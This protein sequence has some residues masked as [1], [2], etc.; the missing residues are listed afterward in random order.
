MMI[1]LIHGECIEE[2]KKLDAKSVNLVLM[3]PPYNI[4]KD[5]TWDNMKDDAY[6]E[7]MGKVF[8]EVSRV[9][10]DNGSMYFFHNDMPLIARL[11][12]NLRTNS[13][14]VFNSFI[15]LDKG[16]FRALA[17]KNPTEKNNLRLWFNVCE[18][19]LCYVKADADG[20]TGLER[21]KLDVNNFQTLRKYAYD[22]LCYIG[23]GHSYQ[24]NTSK[25]NW[26]TGKRNISVT[27]A[28]RSIFS[29]VGGKA[30]HFMRYGSTQWDLC[31]EQTYNEL[32]DTFGIDKWDGFR[33]YESLRQEYESLRQE[34]ESLRP[35]HHLDANHNN[36]WKFKRD[37]GP[38]Y[39]SCQK[40]IDILERIIRCSTDEDMTVLDCFMGS[41]STGVACVNTNRNFIGIEM[42][43]KYYGIATK[44]IDDATK[45]HNK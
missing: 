27:V 17:W 43:E 34:Y 11:M 7:F 18:Y 24:Q 30:D 40:P 31:T 14:M 33:S 44:R 13:D 20:R 29:N 19:C 16:D 38:N 32:I 23:G 5:K 4:N 8:D 21:V 36:V 9:L 1:N 12:E 22:M 37:K 41:G 15:I 35:L 10:V 28:R 3:D 45:E 42:D 2:L 39:H 25:E 26:D 6:I